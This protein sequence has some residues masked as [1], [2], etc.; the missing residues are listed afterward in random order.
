MSTPQRTILIVD[1]TPHDREAYRRYLLA[2]KAFTYTI[3]EQESA[4]EALA[5]CQEK[6]PD[7]IL[8][9]FLLPDQDGLEF[10][11]ELQA[12]TGDNCPPVIMITGQGNEMLAA[13]A[14]KEGAEDYLVKHQMTPDSLRL[15]MHTAIAST[16]LRQQLKRSIERERSVEAALRE[17]QHFIQRVTDTVPGIVYVYDLL[18]QQHIYTNQQLTEIL[19]Y[20]SE[21][22]QA[23]G[24]TFCPQLMHPEDWNRLSDQLNSIA[25]L[26]E[27]EVIELEYRMRHRNGEWHWFSDRV[28]VFTRT[29][30][31]VPHQILGCAIDVS[32]RKQLEAERDQ[33]WVRERIARQ[34]A[35]TANAEKDEFLATVSHELRSPLNA[36]LGWIKLL[37][38]R[39]YDPTATQKALETIERNAK[40]QAQLIEDLLDISRI[41]R[42]Q[43]R[44]YLRPIHL[45][46]VIEAAI[47]T[48]HPMAETK[49]IRIQTHLDP[50]ITPITGDAER[51]QQVVW[52]LLSNAIK[53]TPEVGLIQVRMNQVNS[54]VQIQV[55]DTG[56]GI[57]PEFLPYVFE[58][59]RQAEDA[60]ARSS[61]GLGLGLAIVRNL[62]ELH[63]GSV[64]VE[65][66]GEGL[67]ST[68]T[69][70]LPLRQSWKPGLT[71]Q[72][73]V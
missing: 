64:N 33:L 22:I 67:G 56:K 60:L 35:E 10:L 1:D 25:S 40:L 27:G 21:S 8:L 66:Q 30:T 47:D 24:T 72:G 11:T 5:L 19:G 63:G 65:S 42:G 51:L 43:I 18:Q 28:T 7:G 2:E 15:A 6:L 48:V 41:I 50:A 46:K 55:I 61:Q 14:I 69:V 17:R 9:D 49:R 26:Q 39:Q 37:R 44:L 52:N 32:E 34:Q 58:R 70:C 13:K 68:F 29:A 38:S 59:F 23:M 20:P 62:V 73:E 31:G 45:A 54:Q 16:E 36:I 53:F 3:W 4:Q 71:L 12:Q 57:S